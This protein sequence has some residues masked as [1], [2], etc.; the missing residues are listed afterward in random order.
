MK[1]GSARADSRPNGGHNQKSLV[2]LLKNAVRTDMADD[3]HGGVCRCDPASWRV[4]LF[5]LKGTAAAVDRERE[6]KGGSACGF[7]YH[8]RPPQADG[9]PELGNLHGPFAP[10]MIVHSCPGSK[11]GNGQADSNTGV[12]A[13]TIHTYSLAQDQD[14][15]TS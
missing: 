14:K 7:L 13:I 12:L 3:V 6:T 15:K 4:F 9:K 8:G 11:E 10:R 1:C 2:S 5:P